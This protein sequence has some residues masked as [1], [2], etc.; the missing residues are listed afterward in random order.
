MSSLS[1]LIILLLLLATNH[2]NKHFAENSLTGF[3]TY[4]YDALFTI[5]SLVNL[6]LVT[7]LY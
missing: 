7:F 5:K 6:V 1:R 3:A 2:A 4:H